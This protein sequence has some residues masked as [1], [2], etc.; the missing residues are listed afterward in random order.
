MLHERDRLPEDMH[1][2][3]LLMF[4]FAWFEDALLLASQRSPYRDI[5]RAES[6][7]LTHLAYADMSAAELGRALGITRQAAHRTVLRLLRKGWL[8][9][10]PHRSN[11]RVRNLRP[12]PAVA[13]H[14][15]QKLDAIE[16]QLAESIGSRN[17][18]L[19]RRI[20]AADWG[21]AS[22]GRE[23]QMIRSGREKKASRTATR[24]KR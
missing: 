17:V 1:L 8:V 18:K 11:A 22:T 9:S 19:L 14:A 12:A 10:M 16:A 15:F 7:M 3:N 20:L 13:R 23:A 5:T 21:M 4:R 24:L 2:K 6:R